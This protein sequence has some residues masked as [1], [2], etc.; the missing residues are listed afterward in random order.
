MAWIERIPP[1]EAKGELRKLYAAG[2]DPRTGRVDHILQVHSLHPEGLQAHL[3][4]YRAV[5]RPGQGLDLADRELVAWQV[6]R[7]NGCFY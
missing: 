1:E 7:W 3:A 6:S 2:R 4:L 5:M